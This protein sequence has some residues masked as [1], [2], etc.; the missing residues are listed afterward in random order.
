MEENLVSRKGKRTLIFLI[1]LVWGKIW[2]PLDNICTS[3]L[4]TVD[5]V[6]ASL[7]FIIFKAELPDHDLD[8]RLGGRLQQLLQPDEAPVVLVEDG[9]AL[10][11]KTC[12]QIR[13][14]LVR[15]ITR[16]EAVNNA[17]VETEKLQFSSLWFLNECLWQS[18]KL[19]QKIDVHS[20]PQV[21]GVKPVLQR[22]LK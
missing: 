8:V 20:N 15:V 1:G 22:R 21:S 12:Y 16:L 18:S 10:P 6:V 5:W 3:A 2:N 9:E 17:G 13:E 7:V 19:T 11:A 4:P 14:C